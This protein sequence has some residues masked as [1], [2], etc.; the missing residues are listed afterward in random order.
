M[1]DINGEIVCEKPNNAIYKFEGTIKLGK[2]YETNT[3]ISLSADNMLL[4][5]MSLR[6]TRYTYGIVVFTGHETKIF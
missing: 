5:G 2:P 1:K 6:N 3:Q 4:R